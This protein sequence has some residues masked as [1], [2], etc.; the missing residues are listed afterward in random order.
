[1]SRLF[2]CGL[3]M[4]SLAAPVVAQDAETPAA[5]TTFSSIKVGQYNL[6]EALILADDEFHFNILG[7]ASSTIVELVND[8]PYPSRF[9]SLEL[10]VTTN[11]YKRDPSRGV[12][13]G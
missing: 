8:S 9:D 7:S 11:P 4:I 5:A 13:R 3:L 12:N 1:M 10:T 2:W 6:G